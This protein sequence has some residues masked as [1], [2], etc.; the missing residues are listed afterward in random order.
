MCGLVLGFHQALCNLLMFQRCCVGERGTCKTDTSNIESDPLVVAGDELGQMSPNLPQAVTHRWPSV[1]CA[2]LRGQPV[3]PA[4]SS[5]V[6]RSEPRFMSSW[7]GR[8][9]TEKIPTL[10]FVRESGSTFRNCHCHYFL[11]SFTLNPFSHVAPLLCWRFPLLPLHNLELHLWPKP[12]SLTLFVLDIC[13]KL[14]LPTLRVGS[15]IPHGHASLLAEFR[16]WD[17]MT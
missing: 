2:A 13:W 8:E 10:A 16:I 14:L 7:Q 9:Q 6:V 4:E 11:E 12:L 1:P 15:E 17:C 3:L 5:I